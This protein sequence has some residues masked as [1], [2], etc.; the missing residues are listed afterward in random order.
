LA[1]CGQFDAARIKAFAQGLAKDLSGGAAKP[2]LAA[3]AWGQTREKTLSLP[4]RNQAHLLAVFPTPGR[5]DFQASAE[6]E[7][8]RAALAGQSGLLF[9]DLRDKQGLGYTVT[10]FL[11]QAPKTGFLAFYIGTE[12]DKMG[13]ARDGFRSVVAALRSGLLPGDEVERA[14]NILTGEYY[15]EHQ[16]LGARSN[17]AASLLVQ[18]F[19][20][21]R[22]KEIIAAAQKVTPETLRDLARRWLDWD[23]AYELRVEP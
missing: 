22:D 2:D 17:E 6:L 10:A 18:G 7:V 11:W 23:K 20:L 5:D 14:R 9:R 8:L 4:G 3:P 19:D 13:Q 21:D 15:Q 16:S 12:P 1:V